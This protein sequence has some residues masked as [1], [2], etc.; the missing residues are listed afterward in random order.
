MMPSD[1]LFNLTASPSNFSF[2]VD[3]A[4]VCFQ[5]FVIMERPKLMEVENE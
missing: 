5:E 2:V 3:D 4:H 1:K